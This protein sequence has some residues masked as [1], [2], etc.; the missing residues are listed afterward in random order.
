MVEIAKGQKSGK[1]SQH[2]TVYSQSVFQ[3][4]GY[5]PLLETWLWNVL[6]NSDF[7]KVVFTT[8]RGAGVK[9]CN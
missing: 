9:F 1:L 3:T 5:N 2:S 6:W 8:P 4:Q 7:G